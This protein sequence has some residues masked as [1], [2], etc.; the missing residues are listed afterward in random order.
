MGV[1]RKCDVGSD[2]PRVVTRRNGGVLTVELARQLPGDCVAEW[3]VSLPALLGVNA[4]VTVGDVTVDGMRGGVQAVVSSAGDVR[5]RVLDGHVFIDVGVGDA[6]VAYE[7]ANYGGVTAR[8]RVGDVDLRLAGRAV[9]RSKAPGSGD[10]IAIEGPAQ[11]T[12]RVSANVGDVTINITG[13]AARA[14]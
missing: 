7:G 12:I 9:N 2:E 11:N 1:S 10:Q 4:E 3:T 5:A 14:P 6:N 8:S 13:A